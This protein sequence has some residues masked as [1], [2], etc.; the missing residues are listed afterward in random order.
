MNIEMM[1]HVRAVHSEAFKDLFNPRGSGSFDLK[2]SQ[3]SFVT[4]ISIGQPQA[5]EERGCLCRSDFSN[6]P[7]H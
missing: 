3:I 5:G 4:F 6:E 7:L 2:R 1:M